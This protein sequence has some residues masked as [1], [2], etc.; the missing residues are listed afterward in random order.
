MKI[1]EHFKVAREFDSVLSKLD[2][3]VDGLAVIEMLMMA[4]TNYMNAVLH[5]NEIIPETFDLTHSYKP[6]PENWDD[7]VLPVPTQELLT[8][9]AFM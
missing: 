4:G 3:E 1:E 8:N 7:V 5:A 2:P 6:K 9:M